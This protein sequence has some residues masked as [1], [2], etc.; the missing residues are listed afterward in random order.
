MIA[1]EKTGRRAR[2]IEIEPKYADVIVKRWQD[3]TGKKGTLAATGQSFE[4]LEK[5]RLS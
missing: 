3:F 1:C 4:D 2:L 5:E